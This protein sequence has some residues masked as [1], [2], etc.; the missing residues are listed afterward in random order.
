LSSVFVLGEAMNLYIQ[1]QDPQMQIQPMTWFP[2]AAAC[3]YWAVGRLSSGTAAVRSGLAAAAA[4]L[5][6]VNVQAHTP[7]RHADSIALRNIA[8]LESLAP[9]KNTVF[10]LHG[11]EG[12][13][14][15]LTTMWGA[16]ATD[17]PVFPTEGPARFNAIFVASQAT[18]TPDR[19]PQVSAREVVWL[20]DQALDEGFDVVAGDIWS[21]PEAHWVDW[22]STISGPD[23]P[24]A[25][26][27]ALHERYSAT[28]IGEVPGWTRLYRL[29]RKPGAAPLS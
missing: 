7:S 6:V 29:R 21:A 23:K 15:W 17:A 28:P 9:P 12:M 14:T 19:T 16:G 13:C 27:A 25:I 18:V 24:R 1:P 3:V 10:L 8:I 20:V 4:A 2:F 22:F 11:F 26:R 5:A